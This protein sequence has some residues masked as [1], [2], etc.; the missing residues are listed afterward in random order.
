[1]REVTL[2][3]S[4]IAD[5]A[6]LHQALAAA[7]AFPDYYGSNLDALYD[8]LTDLEEETHLTLRNWERIRPWAAGFRAVLEEAENETANLSV[9]LV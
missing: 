2:D 3:C 6:A 1:M 5:K 9:T 4:G 7:L 8:C